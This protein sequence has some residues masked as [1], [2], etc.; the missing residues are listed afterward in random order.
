MEKISLLTLLIMFLF[1]TGC[2]EY[3]NENICG[4]YVTHWKDE[5]AK[6]SDT[7]IITRQRESKDYQITR[8]M[9]S[10]FYKKSKKPVFK[11]AYW[12]AVFNTTNNSL[13]IDNNGRI[14][15]YYP[16]RNELISGTVIYKK[17]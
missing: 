10:R 8:H 6:T 7:M 1:I 16:Q 3:S 14:L 5:F 9:C 13:L 11:I 12:A 4:V 2:K 15:F 17:M